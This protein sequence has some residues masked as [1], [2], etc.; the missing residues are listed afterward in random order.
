MARILLLNPPGTRPY[1]RDYY[2][3]KEAKADYLYEPV[4]LL[5][6]S[7]VLAEQHQ[8]QVLDCI[9]L[10]LPV[11]EALRRVHAAR[12]DVVVFLSGAVSW[13]EDHLFLGQ[14]KK[15]SKARLIGSGDLFLEE[16]VR[17]LSECDFI[18]ALL[19]DFTTPD[20]LYYLDQEERTEPENM[21]YRKGGKVVQGVLRRAKKGT[22][23]IPPPRHDLFPHHRY[24]Y[25]TVRRP[26]F[27]TVLTDY[28]CPYHCRFCVMGKL[29][30]KVR[31]VANV[32]EELASLAAA[33]FREIYFNDQTFGV[34]RERTLAL[35]EE[36][37]RHQLRFGWQAWSRVDV[38]D[39][40]LL[41]AIKSAGCHTLLFGVE[42][43]NEK[44]LEA[45]KK[46]YGQKEIR[47]TFTLCRRLGIRTLATFIIGLPGETEKDIRRSIDFA[48]NLNPDLVSF[49][50][51][52]P[53]AATEV[54]QEALA[55]G[56]LRDSHMS[57]DQS[58]AYPIMG[59]DYLSAG[60]VWSLKNEA[61]W[62]FYARPGYWW[63]RLLSMRTSYE[64]RRNLVNGWAILHRLVTKRADRP[65]DRWTGEIL[66]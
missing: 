8:V 48:L 10:G 37:R 23:Q 47:Q 60:E 13:H 11:S 27:A 43:A 66:S 34:L 42:S 56:W 46:G 21:I 22:F 30:Y 62:S 51:L 3:S 4:D 29:G 65:E 40:P 63:R 6:L 52:V 33:G 17:I 41:R 19:L 2:C 38:V 15:G 64:L 24:H 16:G 28:G 25:P 1:L 59:N 18:D 12:P 61:I 49:N 9:A 14:I 32:I 26:P 45:Q 55:K 44:T 36:M 5:L 57:L 58:G 39:E 7:G 20:L 31:P 53:R 54:R 35:C 50:V